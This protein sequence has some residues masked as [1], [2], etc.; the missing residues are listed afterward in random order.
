MLSIRRLLLRDLLTLVGA[1][2]GVLCLVFAWGTLQLLERVGDQRARE[3]VASL[4]E[5]LHNG[6]RQSQLLGLAARDWWSAG[7][8]DLDRPE[9]T[10]ALLLPLVERSQL[11]AGIFLHTPQGK[12]LLFTR[13]RPGG[14]H[15]RGPWVTYLFE[16]H[17]GRLLQRRFREAGI[18]LR[19][20]PWEPAFLDPATRPWYLQ[21]L[22]A[23]RPQ[24]VEPYPSSAGTARA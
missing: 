4:G 1:T 8:I 20:S 3:L 18:T 24:W 17:D 23:Y 2:V 6:F 7:L 19:D 21:G 12:G 10:E 15:Q 11:V 16:R 14:S 9:Q 5:D 13:D 22:K